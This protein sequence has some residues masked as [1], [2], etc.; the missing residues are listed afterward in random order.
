MVKTNRGAGTSRRAR[1]YYI[2]DIGAPETVAGY[3]A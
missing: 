2:G 1:T 3:V